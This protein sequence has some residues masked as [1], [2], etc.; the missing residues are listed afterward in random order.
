[1]SNN[2]L[3]HQLIGGGPL[4][5][6]ALHDF[7]SDTSSYQAITPYLQK[8]KITLC[9]ADLRGYGRSKHLS[10][11]FSIDQVMTDVLALADHLGWERF[12]LIGHSMSGQYIQY[13][14]LKNPHRILSLVA[15]ASVPPSGSPIPS[16]LLQQI[17]LAAKGD[18]QIAHGILSFITGSR[19]SQG[20]VNFKV[21][22]WYESSTQE[23]RLAYLDLF[24]TTNFSAQMQHLKTPI[25][26]IV[27]E[28]DQ[29]YGASLAK[30]A[31]LPF[32]DNAKLEVIP[33]STH[34]PIQES[35]CY[36]LGLL[37]GFLALA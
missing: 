17:Q 22:K 29:S 36:L 2:L 4:R 6:I 30:E 11:T 31:I 35:P 37:E 12:H 1:M 18:R 27:G 34:Y 3:G 20:F 33:N 14:A 28:N 7:F 24:T 10:S 21:E 9:L 16:D 15:I 26:V 25:L 23:A 32:Y 5:V 13:I 8:D 19:M